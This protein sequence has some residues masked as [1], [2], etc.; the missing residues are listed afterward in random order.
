MIP[1]SSRDKLEKASRVNYTKIY[2]IEYNIKMHVIGRIDEDHKERFLKNFRLAHPALSSTAIVDPEGEFL[3]DFFSESV[4]SRYST[5]G[6]SSMGYQVD[7]IAAIDSLQQ[8]LWVAWES[9]VTI[10]NHTRGVL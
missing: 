3:E 2:T 5:F 8:H 4:L 6:S 7:N 9:F 1:R 10:V